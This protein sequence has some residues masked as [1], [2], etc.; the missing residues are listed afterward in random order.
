M[1]EAV[2]KESY[3]TLLKR[4]LF[5][6]LGM[7][8]AGFG[9]PGSDRQIDQPRGHV[10]QNGDYMPLTP[11]LISDNPEV[12]APAGTV[13]SSIG[14]WAKYA[15]LHMAADRGHPR[16][17]KAESF[18]KLHSDPF[19]QDYGFGWGF[20]KTKSGKGRV[21]THAGS[22]TLWFA[23]INISPEENLAVLTA[24]NAGSQ[25]ANEACL[26]ADQAIRAFIL[27]SPERN[28]SNTSKSD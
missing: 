8:T 28:D 19:N 12:I 6:P 21:L 18:A 14:D 9:A 11:S 7:T 23:V 17:L 26:E 25:A 27:K 5:E 22:N 15:A 13:H 20:A 10:L 24:T 2:T 16:L 3:E 4:R 1:C